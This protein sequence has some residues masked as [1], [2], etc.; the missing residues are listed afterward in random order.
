MRRRYSFTVP[1]ADNRIAID[2]LVELALATYE[3]KRI[4]YEKLQYLLSMSDLEPSDVGIT[5]P[6]GFIPPS[7]KELDDIME[8]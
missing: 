6:M 8:G 3:K 4:S 1:E 2:N 5:K 7:D